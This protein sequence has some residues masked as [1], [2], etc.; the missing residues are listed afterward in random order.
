MVGWV[1]ASPAERL[2]RSTDINFDLQQ[3]RTSWMIVTLTTLL[4]ALVT[5]LLARGLLAPVKRL[6][7]GT[8]ELRQAIFHTRG[9]RQQ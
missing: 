2:T 5:W 8:H 9:S 3:R 6:V 1:I 7:D 4:A